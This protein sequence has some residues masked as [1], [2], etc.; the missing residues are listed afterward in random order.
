KVSNFILD[1]SQMGANGRLQQVRPKDGN[2]C[3]CDNNYRNLGPR[4]GLA[5]RLT[6]ATVLRSGF[7]MIYA[8]GDYL[9]NQVARAMNQAPDFVE[10][11]LSTLDRVTPRLIL[12]DGFPAVQLPATSVPGPANVGINSQQAKVP[13][14]YSAQWFFE[15]QRELPYD[16]LTTI[17]Y[18]G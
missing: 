11:S 9:T 1:Y 16:L 7:G 13:D 12:K 17:T 4:A 8:Q 10:V 15:L 6:K 3:L 18:A 5:Y 14:Q 2:D